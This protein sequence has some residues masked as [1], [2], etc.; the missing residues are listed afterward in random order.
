[1]GTSNYVKGKFYVYRGGQSAQNEIP[2]LRV[3]VASRFAVNS[4]LEVQSHVDVDPAATALAADII[5]SS[6]PT[7][8]SLYRV[9]FDPIDVPALNNPNDSGKLLRGFEAYSEYP[10][11]TGFLALTEI[12]ICVYPASSL[13]PEQAFDEFLTTTSINA[14][15][16]AVRNP[17]TDIFLEDYTSTGIADISIP[18]P[19]YAEGP[20]GVTLDSSAVPGNILGEASREFNPGP[21]TTYSVRLRSEPCKI[22]KVRFHATSTQFSNNNAHLRFRGRTVRF[23][24]TQKYELGGAYAAG[25]LTN[26]IAQ[27]AMPGIGCQNPD[28][29]DTENG[30]WY[31]MLMNTPL[32]E[33]IRPEYPEGTPL[34]VRMP[35]LT[36]QPGPGESA[37]SLLDIRFGMDIID[38][39]D[40]DFRAPLEEGNF[41]IDTITVQSYPI[42]TD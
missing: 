9:D 5:P 24:W 8:P 32:S 17:V 16:L 6:E 29:N 15:S 12:A 41:T 37:P 34:S 14:G 18:R 38:S 27:Q 25:N 35:N 31:T 3:R 22:Y 26:I 13:P 1:V 42:I 40:H 10:Q 21:E 4:M 30:G 39:Q 19:T 20:F 11:D 36:A 33:D 7:S 2:M 28:K 23:N